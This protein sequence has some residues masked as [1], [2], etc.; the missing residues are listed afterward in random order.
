[1]ILLIEVVENYMKYK[2]AFVINNNNEKDKNFWTFLTQEKF[3]EE[4]LFKLE[5][6]FYVQVNKKNNLLRHITQI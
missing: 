4:V 2:Y 6:C 1:M 5:F 3:Q